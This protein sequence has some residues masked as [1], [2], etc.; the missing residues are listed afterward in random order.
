MEEISIYDTGR[1]LLYSSHGV[2]TEAVKEAPHGPLFN[3]MDS[4]LTVRHRV[5][6]DGR[7][8]HVVNPLINT[9][10]CSTAACH[11]HPSSQKV[12]GALSITIPLGNMRD[13]IYGQTQGTVIFAFILFILI[14]SVIG[15]AVIFLVNPTIRRLQENAAK[16]ARGEYDPV[17]PVFGSD[18]IAELSRSFDEM[19][20]QINERTMDLRAGREM[21]KTLFD[22]I[23]CYL[24]VIDRNYRVL[25][26][27]KA[28]RYQFGDQLGKHCYTGYKGLHEKCLECPVERTFFDALPHQSEE[29][30][31]VHGRETHV[32]VKTA[33]IFDD[34]GKISEVLEMA[35]DVTRLKQLQIELEKKQEEYKY[36]FENVPCYLTV[37]DR[38]YRIMQANKLFENHFGRNLGEHCFKVY[39]KKDFQYEN[40]P[41]EQTFEDGLSHT[42]E[43]VWMRNGNEM[44]IIAT[45]SP[46]TDQQGATVGVMEMCTDITEVVR[47]QQ[48]LALLEKPLPECH[49][50][51]RTY[52]PVSRAASMWLIQGFAAGERSGWVRAGRW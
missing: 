24:T 51:S 30:W 23:P 29:T 8:L 39:K 17:S 34:E 49:T 32:I 25:M 27:N 2:T 40:C 41:V 12:L 38:N 1:R 28:F 16:M 3:N 20:R 10:S 37:V 46:V 35:L 15:L 11:A 18:E 31:R 21:Y 7:W 14:S 26:T 13:T 5:S 4:D 6:N 19:S 9:E 42:S 33:P 36:L 47:L 43:H 50:R 44:R 45:T 22:E 52:C 48:E